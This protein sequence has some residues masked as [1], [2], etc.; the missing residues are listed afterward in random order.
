M[1]VT[2]VFA[3][4]EDKIP[5]F[6]AAPLVEAIRAH[7]HREARFVADLDALVEE[8]A[9]EARPGDMLLTLGAGSI[10]TIGARIVAALAGARR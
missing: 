5:G 6:E 7:G 10:S 3:A 4:G 8:L 9:A 1:F 2:E